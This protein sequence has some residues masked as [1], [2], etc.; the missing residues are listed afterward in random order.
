MKRLV[1]PVAILVVILVIW[2]IQSNIEKR[3]ITGRLIENYLDL[4]TDEITKILTISA[5]DT[6]TFKEEQGRWYFLD[7]QP[8][9]ADSMA[10]GNMISAA[11]TMKV[12]NVISEN[13]ERQRSFL[14][15]DSTGNL[16]QFFHDD[17]LLN[18]IIIGKVASNRTHTYIR[19][20]GSDKVYL[21]EGLLTYTFRRVKSQWLDKTIFSIDPRAISEFELVYSDNSFRLKNKDMVWN[22]SKKP[23]K[24]SVPADTAMVNNYIGR[25]SRL[26]ANDFINA[27]DS[28]LMDFKNFA[29]K[30]NITLIDGTTQSVEFAKQNEDN[31]R[32]YC[33]KPDNDE[34]F[35][36][37][38]SRFAGLLKKYSDFLSE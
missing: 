15:D 19:E 2:L 18:E 23:Y 30:I 10:V 4:N 36:I 34:I 20:P 8:R 35:V 32:V 11:A 28:G 33:R 12:G 31:S 37:Y 27:S 16:I 5:D 13:V 29:L 1:I 26:S 6:L 3:Q 25:I 24:K 38:K 14:V 22:V 21:A 7:P 9:K 17:D